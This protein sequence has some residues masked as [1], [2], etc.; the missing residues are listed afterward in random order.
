MKSFVTTDHVQWTI[1]IPF[2]VL[3]LFSM[4]MKAYSK[5]SN[6]SFACL[7][8]KN[9]LVIVAN[10]F[11][12]QVKATPIISAKM[13]NHTTQLGKSRQLYWCLS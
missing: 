5:Q 10:Q 7:L 4:K 13:R 9:D 6:T 8:K 3:R 1:K 2:L 12:L 11:I